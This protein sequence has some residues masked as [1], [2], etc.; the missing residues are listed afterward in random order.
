MRNVHTLIMR[1]YI[2][3]VMTDDQKIDYRRKRSV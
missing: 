2:K 3:G 1:K